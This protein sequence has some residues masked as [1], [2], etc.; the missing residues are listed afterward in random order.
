M[1]LSATLV[2][3]SMHFQASYGRNSLLALLTPAW[4]LPIMTS[5]TTEHRTQPFF[6][7]CRVNP[8]GEHYYDGISLNPFEVLFVKTK[9]VL[10]GNDWS[11]STLATKYDQWMAAQVSSLH[12]TLHNMLCPFTIVPCTDWAKVQAHLPDLKC[13]KVLKRPHT[14]NVVLSTR[15]PVMQTRICS[16]S[17]TV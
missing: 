2:L 14:V 13:L 12:Q 17:L 3:S 8:Y 5:A 6:C 9:G 4:Q 11:Y 7:P 10:L 1:A 15:G 16:P